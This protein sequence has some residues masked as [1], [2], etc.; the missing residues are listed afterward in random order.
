M[1]RDIIRQFIN[2][3][4]KR[5]VGQATWQERNRVGEFVATW[6]IEC[7]QVISKEFE[8]MAVAYPNVSSDVM[9]YFKL[10][11]HYLSS[12]CCRLDYQR[13]KSHPNGITDAPLGITPG[14]VKGE[15]WHDFE[16]NAYLFTAS[17]LPER[18]KFAVS[19]D[20]QIQTFEQAFHWFCDK[21]NIGRTSA[22]IP[23]L[24][25]R[26]RLI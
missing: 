17:K 10:G 22:D 24:P 20:P 26:T 16:H 2:D 7:N 3:Q 13:D 23:L 21:L 8:I 11:L 4:T 15:H 5:I 12:P 6:Q 25:T 18:F 14:I 1:H 19:V 9:P